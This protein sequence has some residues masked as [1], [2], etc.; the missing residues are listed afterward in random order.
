[1]SLTSAPAMRRRMAERNIAITGQDRDADIEEHLVVDAGDQAGAEP[2]RV[3]VN[4][5]GQDIAGPCRHDRRRMI[6]PHRQSPGPT[7]TEASDTSQPRRDRLG[8]GPTAVALG[9][10]RHLAQV[11]RLGP[12][13]ID[14]CQLVNSKAAER[15][16]QHRPGPATADDR[17]G[18]R[19][20][21]IPDLE[22]AQGPDRTRPSFDGGP[23]TASARRDGRRGAERLGGSNPVHAGP[24]QPQ[25]VDR[26]EEVPDAGGPA[27]SAS[28]RTPPEPEHPGRLDR[29]RRGEVDG[30]L[31]GADLEEPVCRSRLAASSQP[32]EPVCIAP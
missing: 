18:K 8:L 15:F 25:L 16:G 12:I 13:G 2:G 9:D 1:M 23:A 7:G 14:Q 29:G 24:H 3:I 31:S 20:E 5:A 21:A 4:A 11:V 19:R 30:R 32:G 28:P 17:H 27:P 6:Q 26:L 10:Q 22:T